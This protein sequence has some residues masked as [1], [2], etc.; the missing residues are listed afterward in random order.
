MLFGIIILLKRLDSLLF[1]SIFE[2][3]F[4]F[5][6]GGVTEGEAGKKDFASVIP[7]HGGLMDRFD[8]MFIMIYFT[9]MYYSTF[10][11]YE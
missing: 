4:S 3:C 5:G 9:S 1:V 11:K 7:G 2:D 8:C 10:I 6:V